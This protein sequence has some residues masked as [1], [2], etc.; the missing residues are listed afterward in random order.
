MRWGSWVV[1]M[2]L[3]ASLARADLPIKEPYTFKRWMD[4]EAWVK[5]PSA[6][7]PGARLQLSR[8]TKLE[9]QCP[10]ITDFPGST[11]PQ[12]GCQAP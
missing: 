11:Q 8:P 4:V 12:E 3:A 10:S 6:R 1:G 7:G 9:S 5:E 2:C